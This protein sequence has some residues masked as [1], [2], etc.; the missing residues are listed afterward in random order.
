MGSLPDKP[1]GLVGSTGKPPERIE[2]APGSATRPTR[3]LLCGALDLTRPTLFRDGSWCGHGGT[4]IPGNPKYGR[5][6]PTD[7]DAEALYARLMREASEAGLIVQAYGGVATVAIP[8]EQR[9]RE[10]LRAEVL[11][12]A[13]LNET[14]EVLR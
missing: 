4:S 9:K 11:Q 8:R 14:R 1:A 2:G 5:T 7:K 13:Q 12:A 10:G 6:A 3:C